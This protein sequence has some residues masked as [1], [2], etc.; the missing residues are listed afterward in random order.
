MKA[1]SIAVIV[2]MPDTHLIGLLLF[3]FTVFFTTYELIQ[4]Y[5]KENN[6]IKHRGVM[7][8]YD[9]ETRAT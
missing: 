4:T 5:G 6:R 3:R 1:I 9:P 8:F 2:S 7:M